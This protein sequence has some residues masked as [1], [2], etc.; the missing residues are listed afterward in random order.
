MEELQLQAVTITVCTKERFRRVKRF[1]GERTNVIDDRRPGRP[2]TKH[3]D[4]HIRDSRRTSFHKT[5]SEMGIK[6]RKKRCMNGL[7]PNRIHFI[8]NKKVVD[9]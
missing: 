5:T 4:Q 2:S 3:I 9:R 7:S 8:V 6:R 1:K